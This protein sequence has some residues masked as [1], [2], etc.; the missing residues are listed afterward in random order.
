MIVAGIDPG[1]TGAMVILNDFVPLTVC[2]LP[3][4]GKDPAWS[5]WAREWGTAIDLAGIDAAVIEDVSA[6]PG[7]GVTSM[8]KFGETLGFAHAIV[9]SCASVPIH[10]PTPRTWKAKMGLTSDKTDAREECRRLMPTLT[11]DVARV[12]DDGVAEAA[13]I[14]YYGRKFLC[15]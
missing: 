8:F 1:K 13:L 11:K 12:K 14:A 3:L 5:Q 2:R 15:V 6:R 7:Q 10:W 4:A 9:L